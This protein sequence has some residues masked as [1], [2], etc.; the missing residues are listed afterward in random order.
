MDAVRRAI[1]RCGES[2]TASD[3]SRMIGV[4]ERDSG[5]NGVF[6]ALDQ[7]A[8]NGELTKTLMKRGQLRPKSVFTRTVL[9]RSEELDQLSQ[10]FAARF[11]QDLALKWGSARRAQAE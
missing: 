9:F 4:S 5:Y 3:V 1:P 7:L 6:S 10:A 11:V 8:A 2:F